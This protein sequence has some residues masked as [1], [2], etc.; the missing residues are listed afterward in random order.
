MM[1]DLAAS[2]E[3]L[4]DRHDVN[5]NVYDLV[6]DILG[7]FIN[8]KEDCGVGVVIV[9]DLLVFVDDYRREEVEQRASLYPPIAMKMRIGRKLDGST[10]IFPCCLW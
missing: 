4:F 10:L 6:M 7:V 5:F 2:F 8:R 9:E 3:S 1:K